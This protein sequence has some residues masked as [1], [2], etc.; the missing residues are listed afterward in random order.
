MCSSFRRIMERVS[1]ESVHQVLTSVR[2]VVHFNFCNR[3][4]NFH[5]QLLLRVFKI[6]GHVLYIS[7]VIILKIVIR[8]KVK[9]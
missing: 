5:V 1:V 8:L 4:E 2:F 6:Y 9:Q 7:H 3:I